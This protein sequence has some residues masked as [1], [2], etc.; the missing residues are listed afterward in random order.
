MEYQI[1]E[2]TF[3]LLHKKLVSSVFKIL[4]L[5]LGHPIFLI[6]WGLSVTPKALKDRKPQL[7]GHNDGLFWYASADC[8]SK[9]QSWWSIPFWKKTHRLAL[10]N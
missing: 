3:S 7:E 5:H 8:L 9:M 2:V 4:S 6:V 10:K 1:L